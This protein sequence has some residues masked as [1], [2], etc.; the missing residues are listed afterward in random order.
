MTLQLSLPKFSIC[1]TTARPKKWKVAYNTWLNQAKHPEDV[2]YVLVV[3]AR[4]GFTELPKLRPQDKVVWNTDKMCLVGGANV[5]CANAT[6]QILIIN[7]D[8]V[9]P[10]KGWDEALGALI[11]K[12][13]LSE[14]F[15]IHTSSGT[16]A[17][18][19]HLMVCQI[20]S[21]ARYRRLGY[22]LYPGYDSMYADD[23]FSEHARY[24]GVVIDAR[25][26]V[27]THVHPVYSKTEWDP[28]YEHENK[29]ASYAKGEA[30]LATRRSQAFGSQSGP[31]LDLQPRKTVV[32][33]LPGIQFSQGWVS[34]WTSLFGSLMTKYI[35]VPI[36]GYSTNVYAC[37]DSL[38]DHALHHVHP[39]PDYVLWMD[40]DNILT[41]ETFVQLVNDLETHPELDGVA[42]WCW[43]L[44]N[45]FGGEVTV[46]S[47]GSLL[48]TGQTR[49]WNYEELMSGEGYLKEFGSGGM[50]GILMR[51][52][53]L[54]KVGRRPF[55]PIISEDYP[56]GLSGE[57][58]SFF[59]NARTRGQCRFAVDKRL[60][61]PHLR[62]GCPEPQFIV[63]QQ[64]LAR[65]T[66]SELQTQEK[67]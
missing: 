14:E 47:V 24:D 5:A 30:I 29:K 45:V 9:F 13:P 18:S 27:F 40:D 28:V 54:Q 50:P 36:F 55:T 35:T 6:G 48:E 2:E 25:H 66:G 58:V 15:V 44:K 64:N 7:S 46:T 3:D 1:H 61:I 62:L 39:T 65:Q 17:D 37:R 52:D 38:F 11:D 8:D 20:L 49:L 67:L 21:R 41:P 57:D 59:L 26:L 16:P 33:C 31:V 10:S 12:D 51:Y 56:H 43:V 23:D 22:G 4:W 42:A 60:K 63:D 32:C 53:T 19:K 34:N